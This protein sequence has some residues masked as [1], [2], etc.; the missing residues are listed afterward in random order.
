MKHNF[1]Q[2]NAA[3][4]AQKTGG[5]AS[6]CQTS[7]SEGARQMTTML[8]G[9]TIEHPFSIHSA[10]FGTTRIPRGW[11]YVACMLMVLTLFVGH[12][13]ATEY[14]LLDHSNKTFTGEFVCSPATPTDDA[15][16]FADKTFACY[17]NTTGNLASWSNKAAET[18][19]IDYDVKT[20]S[21]TF[22][23]Y[24]GNTSSDLPQLYYAVFDESTSAHSA[25]DVAQTTIGD[26]IPKGN[27]TPQYT[28]RTFT[29]TR[30][31]NARVCIYTSKASNT[32][33]YQI[34]ANE[35]GTALPKVGEG[36]YVL[37]M[38]KGRFALNGSKYGKIDGNIEIY[39]YNSYNMANSANVQFDKNKTSSVY[40]KFTTP[41]SPGKLKLTYSNGQ[42]AYNTSA[43]G[44]GATSITSGTEYTL[45]GNTTYY[46]VN[47]GSATSNVT[48]L[49]FVASTPDPDPEPEC[50]TPTIAW[51]TGSTANISVYDE[52]A[53]TNLGINVTEYTG[54][55][56][57]ALTGDD[58][59]ALSN[60]SKTGCTVTGKA[61]AYGT[62]TLTASFTLS[63][64]ATLCDGTYS[65]TKTI[66]I[67]ECVAE[68]AALTN[69]IARFQVPCDVDNT[70]VLTSPINRT[71][72]TCT[73]A[74]V[75]GNGNWYQNPTS[76]LWYG[77]MNGDGTSKYIT[78]TLTSGSF[79]AGD[80]VTIA[81]NRDNTT[82]SGFKIKSTS[83][84]TVEPASTAS[85]VEATGTYTLTAD[86]INND[87]SLTFYRSNS[88]TYVNRIIITRPVS[89]AATVPGDISKGTLSAG[90]LTLN[91]AGSPLSGDTWYW[92]SSAS[93]TD[94]TN[95]GTSYGVSAAGTY[96]VRS[97]NTTGTCWSAA[98]SFTVTAEDLVESY[99]VVYKDGET[100]LGSETVEVGEH[101]T[102]AGIS[103]TK[104][105]YT[106]AAWQESGVDKALNTV[107]AAN[108]ETVT[109]TARYTAQYTSGTYEFTGHLTMGTSPQMTINN[110]TDG[111][112][113]NAG[114]ID[115]IYVSAQ[116]IGYEAS[117]DYGGW[118]LKTTDGTLRFMVGTVCGIR[119]TLGEANPLRIAYTEGGVA[120][121]ADIA[122]STTSTI[123]KADANSLVTLTNFTA[124]NKTVTLKKIEILPL[125]N[126]TYTD[127][128]GD[129]SGSASNVA[130]VTLPSPTETE[131]TVETVDY[132]F[133][134]WKADQIVTVN[135]V[136]KSVGTLLNAGDVAVLGANTTFTAQWAEV[137]PKYEITKGT[138]TNGDFTI[139]VAEQEAGET[140]TLTATP[141]EDYLFSAWEAYKTGD[142]TTTV[143]VTNNAFTMP[144]Y[145]VTV[146]ATFA[147]DPRQ[148]VL[149]L[150]ATAEETV[151][152][153]D[154]LYA[155][156]KDIYNVKIEAPAS[157]TLT[158]YAL[159]V[160][161]ESIGG[162]SSA[163]AVAG[164]KTT[165]VPVLNTKSY[166]YPSGRWNWGTPN[167]GTS[168]KGATLNSAYCNIAN[169]PLFTDVTVS[170][171]FFEITDDAAAKCMQPVG[172]FSSGYEGY[173]L[174]TT[175]NA[176]SGNGCAIHE[177]PAGTTAR[178]VSSGKYL[179]IS[180]SNAKLDALNANGQKLFQNA[181][182]YLIGNTAWEPIVVPTV[183]AITADPSIAYSVGDNIELTASATG[184]SATTTYTWYKGATLEA[185]IEAGAVQA[186]ETAA[187][188]GNVY[189]KASCA[190]GDAGTYWC[191]IS[192]GTDC[193]VS[194][195]L[196]I[197]VSDIAY[198]ISFSSA[199][200]TAP[201]STTGVSYT[202][203]ELSA[204]GWEH[205]GWT[206]SIDVTVDAATVTAG[207]KIANG[208][209]A[210]FGAD[211]TFTAVWTQVFDVTFNLQD[212]GAAVATQHI[213]NGGKVTEPND[214]FEVG[215]I[216]GGWY[217]EAACTNE[218][219][220][221]N[222]V[223]AED[224]ELFAKWTAF[225]GCVELWP[226]TSGDAPAA[227]GD[228]IVMQTGSNGATMTALANVDKLTYTA[229]G[230]QFGSTSGVKAKVVLNNEMSAS[231]GT[232]ISMTLVAAGTGTRGLNLYDANGNKINAFTC[233]VDGTNPASNGAEET[234]TY[235]VVENDGLDGSNEF[236]LWRNNTVILKT[237]KV[238]N[239]GAT[240]IYH[241]LTSAVDPTGKGTVTL[242][243]SSVREGYT[244]TAT[245]SE[246]DEAYEFDEW[247]ISG[248]GASI[249]DA[250]ANPAT[251]TMG[252]ADAVVTL[253]LK[254]ATPKHTVTF[255]KMGKGDDIASQSVKEGDLIEE[256]T[257]TEP[258][259]WILE[260]W[261]TENT[262]D[263]KWDFAN[264]V[265]STSDIELFANWVA[266]TSIKLIVAGAINTT[267]YYTG[268][269][270]S[271]SPVT[272]ET[273]DY[274]YA[275][276]G[277]T[278]SSPSVN[279]L[280]KVITYNATTTRTKVMVDVYN[281]AT[282]ARSVK[283]W[284]V[285]EGEVTSTELAS[286][287]LDNGAN[288]RVTSSYYDFNNLDGKNRTIYI[289][290]PSSVSDVAFLQVKVVESGDPIHMFGEAGYSVSFNKGRLVGPSS[291][292]LT[293]EGMTYHLASNY[294]ALN[295]NPAVLTKNKSYRIDLAN[296]VTMNVTT[297]N[298]A[299]FYVDQATDGTAHQTASAGSHSYDLTA[300][301]WYINVAGSNL[302][303]SSIS[304]IAPKCEA[305]AFN[306]LANSDICSGDAYVAL[307]GTGT[308]SDGGSITYKWY[309]EGDAET[310]LAT[311]ATYTPIADGSYYVVALHH[312][313]GY[314]DNEVTSDVVTVKTHAGTAISEP[315]ADQ[316]GNVDDVVAL[317][318]VASGKNLHYEWK[319]C[320]TINGEY[321]A[322]VGAADAASL[323]VTI[324]EGMDKYY[325]V[326]VSSD[327]GDAQESVA[328]V[329]QYVPVAQANVTGSI[330][331]DWT[332][333]A[334]V[335]EIKL[336]T[337]STPKKNEG[338]VMANGAATIY[339][340]A[341]FESDKLYLEGEYIVRDGKYFQGQT[342]KFNATVAGL[343]HMKFS[344]T[345]NNAARELYINGVGTGN[346]S[347]NATM[348]YSDYVEV[349]AG[350]VSITA[351]LAD[352]SED[353][354]QKYI[355]VSEIEFY[356][357]D[358]VR[359]DS[360]IAPGE[361]G[362][363][364]YPNGHIVVGADMYQMAGVDENHKFAFDQVT[365]TEPGV[366]YLFEATG[367]DPIKFYK[368]T[369]AAA[370]EAGTSNG[371]V[372]TFAAMTLTPA[373]GEN[374]YYFQGT[375]FYSVAAR[376]K[377]LSVPANRCYVDLNEP[378]PAAAPAP[379]RRRITFGVNGTNTATGVENIQTTEISIQKVLIDGKMYILRGE[380]MYDATG[381]L[382]K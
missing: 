292:N 89:C 68:P 141:N 169:H 381:R 125:Y 279:A 11:K 119:V 130:E 160:L 263:T 99:T 149:Y 221:A 181:A 131:V 113:Y 40:I 71:E 298:N 331:W 59:V 256:P 339:N 335:S 225:S 327:C 90:V 199:H 148:K 8:E 147:A 261:Y 267:N 205:Q 151:K 111:Q 363:V 78:I 72:C 364:C 45:S 76:K 55:I 242:G 61:D 240:I 124:N 100:T 166:F 295:S 349:P 38:N 374:L 120:K 109:L 297:A 164:C 380:K 75:G 84:N 102:A 18:Y 270:M 35:T 252:T 180:V 338:F 17:V 348:I 326:V 83:G 233:W 356:A 328:H 359:D 353:A 44:T 308:V 101:P 315:L 15:R 316:R 137:V 88:S 277:G 95:S 81:I 134:G 30:S 167:A 346:T 323:N 132:S 218:W 322:V 152:A 41:A 77:K 20:T 2:I 24:V 33:I 251:I 67:K 219:D 332:N 246:I 86:D 210:T 301:T 209:I 133:T 144:A 286:I 1:L 16:T 202:L 39:A 43:S 379:G 227:V 248:T 121:S 112:N 382:V 253:K 156:L 211:V 34:I 272:I 170:E 311:T 284:G 226:A 250:S 360:W 183:A 87:G 142:Q 345:G 342:I 318:V 220:F 5:G 94:Q 187:N 371:M 278:T 28:T 80:V 309:A 329:T 155:A 206:A 174:A 104:E 63:G 249:A 184:V 269:T 82:K 296:A 236:Q 324:T 320:A 117:G 260:G 107:S 305:P 53:A 162:T 201:T 182:A 300:G 27:S 36:G 189:A 128:T 31:K 123:Y 259:G 313:D 243:V 288:K 375:H 37:N 58:I 65:V 178:G 196:A 188:D 70:Q 176:E 268:A 23:I 177:I 378:H 127:G 373:E 114:R 265:M 369:A 195:S 254:A 165:S 145:A 6:Q 223:V 60:Q 138:H 168:V 173:T 216:F 343:V 372:G 358:Q 344:N 73:F 352:K 365:V 26:A 153:N 237:L 215:Q 7:R 361:L 32:K 146:N 351:Y 255:N 347:A 198:N 143:T 129:A 281:K 54:N 304:F 306:A 213:Q 285:V 325:K 239:C 238:E 62:A 50:T 13:W 118:K 29:V 310:V 110:S 204:S 336:T 19:T 299:T 48:Q 337:T 230:L 217:K 244:T 97:Y 190:L 192:N 197:T 25:P 280:N 231:A 175:P 22:T 64:D 302:N 275:Q 350:E 291:T 52:L 229:N 140:V 49:E 56:T 207:T 208:K 98:K 282:S 224:T 85:G 126:V 368:T 321:T 66:T 116:K 370:A 103:T 283:I 91:A 186:A 12:M 262:F 105:F 3:K 273:V 150:T 290:V 171:G 194:A 276:L 355:R 258:E 14:A 341:N 362:T 4:A 193:E 79:Q 51:A 377:N 235:T 289:G 179:M 108:G 357:L 106:F 93:G 10:P 69:E 42:M 340:N 96:Y 303:I 159:V 245:Y 47:T 222:D 367:Y 74:G 21:T 92:Q 139:S 376:T 154:K 266:D 314:T 57:W 46:L 214:P 135:D 257:V 200:G 330:A 191:V 333:A 122:K 172:S 115:N 9:A 203:P 354:S 232:K 287:D 212:H 158:D 319:E 241:D 312:V 247:Q 317:E 307:D 264:D 294:Q 234:F 136:E 293:F 334:S 274:D 161:H 366:P 157:Q 185:A 163:A 271:E 228:A